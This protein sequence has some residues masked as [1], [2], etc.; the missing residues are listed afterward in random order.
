MFECGAKG[1]I[2]DYV[3][4]AQPVMGRDYTFHW[5]VSARKGE[6][7]WVVLNTIYRTEELAL[8]VYTDFIIFIAQHDDSAVD[9]ELARIASYNL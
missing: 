1:S 5:V 2:R 7:E 9:A 6:G 4:S 3:V 8:R